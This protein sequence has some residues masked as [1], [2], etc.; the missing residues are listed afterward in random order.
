MTTT[1]ATTTTTTVNS[2]TFQSQNIPRG[3]F[4]DPNKSLIMNFQVEL[5]AKS[6]LSVQACQCGVRLTLQLQA[7]VK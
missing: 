5:Y 7:I 4:S 1:T 3:H 2:G 6:L